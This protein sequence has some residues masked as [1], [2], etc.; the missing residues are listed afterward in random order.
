MVG[1][2]IKGTSSIICTSGTAFAVFDINLMLQA[3]Y[4][5]PFAITDILIED[6]SFDR[7][8]ILLAT[9]KNIRQIDPYTGKEIWSG[10]DLLGGIPPQSL[11]YAPDLGANKR[12][13]FATK[14]AM[15]LTQ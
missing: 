8:N 15:Y 10:P 14:D 6:S 3:D 5:F 9:T 1:E 12:L 11:R 4:V 13:M 7:K 2:L